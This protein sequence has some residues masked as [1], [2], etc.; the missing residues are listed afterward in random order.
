MLVDFR[1]ISSASTVTLKVQ[2]TMSANCWSPWRTAG[3]SGSFEMI[4]GRMTKSSAVAGGGTLAAL[5]EY[6]LDES[7]V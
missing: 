3:A 1:P 5:V 6:R 2:R 7:L 4:S